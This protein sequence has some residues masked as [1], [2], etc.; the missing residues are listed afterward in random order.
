VFISKQ[1]NY[2]YIGFMIAG[3]CRL[4]SIRGQNLLGYGKK[5]KF[6]TTINLNMKKATLL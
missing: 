1:D 3:G 4:V 6:V 5:N 2:F